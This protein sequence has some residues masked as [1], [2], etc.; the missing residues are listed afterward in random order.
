MKFSNISL[1]SK[2][3]YSFAIVSILSI[4]QAVAVWMSIKSI[5][6]QIA[7]ISKLSIPQ[8]ERMS[9]VQL[10]ITRASLETR[11][12]MLMRSAEKRKAAITEINRLKSESEMTLEEFGKNITSEVGQK[13]F[14]EVQK[15]KVD[16]WSAAS[17]VIP[18]IEN[19]QINEAIDMLETIIIPARNRLLGAINA[20]KE[21]QRNLLNEKTEKA[22]EEIKSSEANVFLFALAAAILGCVI[23]TVLARKLSHPLIR[24]VASAKQIAAGDLS[25][26]IQTTGKD[27]TGQLLVALSEMQIKLNGLVADVRQNAEILSIA[28][29]EIAH[30]NQDLSARTETQAS[31]LEQT[32]ASMDELGSTVRHNTER[33]EEAN[34]LAVNAT[35]VAGKGGEIVGN[36]IKTMKEI[37]DSS[38][39]ITEIIGVIESIAFQTNILALN[40]AVE[41]ARAG[42]HGR[43]F[44]VVASEVRTLAGRSAGAAKEIKILI[45]DSLIKVKE[46]IDQVDNAG[47]TM[48][49]IVSSI[50]KVSKIMGE[51]NLASSDQAFGVSQVGQAVSQMDQTTQQN[52]ALVEQMAAAANSMKDQAG[53][54][55]RSVA[56]FKLDNSH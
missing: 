39:R 15:S 52:A 45:N 37:D 6:V 2:L 29:A 36:V 48:L 18:L 53:E 9:S 46:G 26:V 49:E 22:L 20:Q 25:Q 54:L 35:E 33:A 5:E 11:H 16:F 55:V 30:G 13:Q 12:A 3:F 34:Q 24:A 23:P 42:E 38:K 4:S 28:S 8:N 32:C 40:A 1:A 56:V 21:Y 19:D 51:I 41:A 44:A 14:K 47:S 50:T 43:G 27:E 17:G 10:A 31:A 7:Q